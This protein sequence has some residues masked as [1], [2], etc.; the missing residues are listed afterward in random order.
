MNGSAAIYVRISRDKEGEEFGVKRQEADCRALAE[1]L[2]LT[3]HDVYQDNDIGASRL[4][5]KR[6]V[7]EG[8]NRLLSDAKAGVFTHVLA[9][10]SSRLTRT[11]RDI[12][13]FTELAA[14][15]YGISFATVVSGRLDFATSDGLMMAEILAA[16]DAGEANRISERQKRT[17]L[18]NALEGKPKLQNQRPFGW[19]RDGVTIVPEEAA[20]IREAV[21]KI[22]DG[23]SITSIAREWEKRGIKTA[24]GSATW[25]WSPLQRL[26]TGWRTA[27]VR[28]YH[29]EPVRDAQGQLVRGQWE[30]IISLDQREAALAMLGK[31]ARLKQRQGS[32]LLSGVVMCSL[33]N[34]RM[35]GALANSSRPSTYTCSKGSGHN[36]ISAD[37]LEWYVEGQ[38]VHHIVRRAEEMAYHGGFSAEKAEVVWQGQERYDILNRKMAELW[39]AYHAD[40]LTITEVTAQQARM[41]DE[42]AALEDDRRGFLEAHAKPSGEFSNSFQVWQ[43]AVGDWPNKPL[44]E[45]ALLIRHE[46]EYV[47]VKKGQKGRA[48]WGAESFEKRLEFV[49]KDSPQGDFGPVEASTLAVDGLPEEWAAR[50]EE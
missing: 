50:P 48:G 4:T 1:R 10:S 21:D 47:Y 34:E 14:K 13:T 9:Y 5:N 28:T 18:E 19:E 7:R 43:H 16:I 39:E 3:V 6:K 25:S 41:R 40:A 20:L 23:A 45:R 49:W 27:G 15:P 33:C 2:G 36:A 37:K 44:S 29:R 35:Y 31:R 38:V 26:L 17:F 12:G 32:W 8:Y 24:A 42:L 46:L 11:T 30:P 22:I